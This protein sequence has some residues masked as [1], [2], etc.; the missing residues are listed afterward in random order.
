VLGVDGL[1]VF[2]VG[3][4]GLS[5]PCHIFARFIAGVN[6]ACFFQMLPCIEKERHALALAV[7][8][9]WASD[10]W[11]FVPSAAEPLKIFDGTVGKLWFTAVGVNVLIA[12]DQLAAKFAGTLHRDPKSARMSEV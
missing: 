4:G 2:F 5:G 10:I 12:V 7:G 8:P 1:A 11:A 3:V 6:K 9:D